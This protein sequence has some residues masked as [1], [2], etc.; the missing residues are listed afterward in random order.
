MKFLLV[1]L[2]LLLHTIGFCNFEIQTTD[3]PKKIIIFGAGYV[4]CV[5]GACLAK[6]GH[7]VTFIDP[8]KDRV[9][10]LNEKK[11][12]I[13]ESHLEE[14]ICQGVE[15]GLIEAKCTL[16]EEILEADIA[17]IAVQTPTNE[18]GIQQLDCL[19]N[20]LNTL[21]KVA[22]KRKKPLI[23]SIRS[24]L[25]P[26]SFQKLKK[27]C[28]KNN[29]YISL[30]VNP[31]FLRE[32][33]AVNDF[34]H[35]PFCIAGGDDFNAVQ[36]V[37]SLYE[38]ISKKQFAVNAETAC[39][40]K[41]TCN[42]FHATKIAFANEIS[43]IC[44]ST[45]VN[46]VQLMEIFCED[47]TLNCSSSYL[48]PGFCFGG[49]CLVKDLKA[50]ISIN[51]SPEDSLPLL[52]AIL[53]SNQHRFQIVVDKILQGNHCNLAILGMSFKMNSD[54]VRESPFVHLIERLNQEGIPL[55][56]FDPDIRLERLS[57]CY[58]HLV[59]LITNDV[60][61]ALEKSDG[62]VLCKKLLNE[63]Q[64]R[65]LKNAGITI[66]DLGYFSLRENVN[67]LP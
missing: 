14:L 34:F 52:S 19:E 58:D 26:A 60:S 43:H 10:A 67:E 3:H 16:S 2:F 11:S 20:V 36:T 40:L 22:N 51:D 46:P 8:D 12:P 47:K 48:R 50:L 28:I 7:K 24:T 5:S 55:S 53:P 56:I 54:D 31:E 64:M 6:C 57:N 35:P 4:G 27:D 38:H 45:D 25:L 18:Q 37:L 32:S 61:S 49:P 42:A 30:V 23:V 63:N 17:F 9:N 13:F 21:Y 65:Q 59:P 29:A 15:R 39:M 33:T 66:Y 1:F 62:V 44:A 41:Y